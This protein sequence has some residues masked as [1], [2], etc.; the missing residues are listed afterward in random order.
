MCG[1][2]TWERLCRRSWR[3]TRLSWTGRCA[4][5]WGVDTGHRTC[6]DTGHGH[7]RRMRTQ[8]CAWPAFMLTCRQA[9]TSA[10]SP[11]MRVPMCGHGCVDMHGNTMQGCVDMDV[12][13]HGYTMQECTLTWS[14]RVHAHMFH[15]GA[16]GTCFSPTRTASYL[17]LY[18]CAWKSF[19]RHV[20]PAMCRSPHCDRTSFF[21]SLSASYLIADTTP[22]LR[23]LLRYP[24]ASAIPDLIADSKPSSTSPASTMCA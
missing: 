23:H 8:T 3:A 19:S 2:V 6:V 7:I 10:C 22:F 11:T 17:V 1:Y 4:H 24:S 16:C 14:M 9:G 20:H 13:M 15:A 18:S 12:C 21:L 5:V